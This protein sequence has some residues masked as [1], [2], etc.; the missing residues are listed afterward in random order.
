MER[1]AFDREGR[2]AAQADR[3]RDRHAEDEEEKEAQ[4]EDREFHGFT[5]RCPAG[6]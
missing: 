2:Q 6:A 3:E 5:R 4:A 1:Q